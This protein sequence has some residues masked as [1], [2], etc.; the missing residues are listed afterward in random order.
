M[1]LGAG[2]PALYGER[3]VRVTI[4]LP[5]AL[6]ATLRVVARDRCESISS[7]MAS[8]L[9]GWLVLPGGSVGVVIGNSMTES[10]PVIESSKIESNLVEEI[11]D[12]IEREAFA[13]GW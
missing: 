3:R 8:A 13:D 9:A 7:I 4:T 6:E 2:R 11:S 10:M 1:R 12:G 5:P